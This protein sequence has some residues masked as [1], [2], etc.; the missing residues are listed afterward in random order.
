MSQ[1]P[2]RR[3]RSRIQAESGNAYALDPGKERF[4]GVEAV[5][6]AR[7]EC[8]DPERS[9]AGRT[10]AW[11]GSHG[12]FEHT[13]LTRRS[14]IDAGFQPRRRDL[15][16]GA[17]ARSRRQYARQ[18]AGLRGH[19]GWP[20]RPTSSQGRSHLGRD[21]R[22]R[23]GTDRLATPDRGAT[24]GARLADDPAFLWNLGPHHGGAGGAA[25]RP[26][27]G[28]SHRA[29]AAAQHRPPRQVPRDPHGAR[30]YP[31]GEP[32]IQPGLLPGRSALAV[33]RRAV[34]PRA[35]R[36]PTTIRH[37]HHLPP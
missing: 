1:G 28:H 11:P 23:P 17:I 35:T 32:P 3:A 4:P 16:V 6:S 18:L 13:R 5:R 33:Q 19:P 22:S 30:G 15:D 20:G 2:P 26:H 27:P 12:G 10:G 31:P 25:R 21:T 29:D 7:L 34:Q 36:R 9:G 24:A 37:Q 8:P 14:W